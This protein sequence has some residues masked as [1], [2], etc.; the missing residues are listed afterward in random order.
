MPDTTTACELGFGQGI[1]VNIHAAGGPSLWHATDFNP[2]Q[3]GFAQSLASDSGAQAHLHDQAFAEFCGRHDLPDFDFIGLHGIW[4]W[5]SDDNRRVIVDLL[6]RRLKV[7]GVLYISYNTLPGWSAFAPMRHLMALHAQTMGSQGMG[8]VSR[9]DGAIG[10]ADK[11]MA[12]NPAFGRAY[13]QV[14]E[15]LKSIKEQNRHY[16]AHEY[17]N[18]D[19]QPMHFAAMAQWLAPAKL[20]FAC[21]AH[22]LDHVDGI[23]LRAEQLALLKTI[24]DPVFRESVRDF[25]V[26]QQFR[27]DYWVKGPRKLQTQDALEALHAH[28]VVLVSHRPDIALKVKG[29]LG[30]STLTEK[31]YA[32]VLDLLADHQPRTLGQIATE[33]GR[34]SKRIAQIQE[35]AV[36]LTG[37]GHLAGVQDDVVI[38]NARPHTDRLNARLLR[39][40]RSSADIKHL[41]SPVTGGGVSVGRFAQLFLAARQQGL[42]LPAE[43]AASAWAT[44]QLQNQKVIKDD[45]VLEGADE[46]LA[47][48]TASATRFADKQ[49]PLLQALQVA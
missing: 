23:N 45:K 37:A 12:T 8:T 22:Y 19:W 42:L 9:V 24:P 10:F 5:I 44:L 43:W 20:S 2:A 26:N 31:V 36:I 49:L 34:G 27:R 35:V 29:A 32:P 28:Q 18:R 3:A 16:L 13:P 40:A 46:N 4:S 21:S 25:M 17:F 1:S 30:S 48:L 11:L 39:H 14:A 33:L 6:R 15:R 41:A 38:R 47:E 7:G